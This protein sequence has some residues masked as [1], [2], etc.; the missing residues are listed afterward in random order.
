MNT[1]SMNSLALSSRRLKGMGIL[2]MVF[3]LVMAIDAWFKWQPG[4]INHFTSYLTGSLDSRRPGEPTL[5]CL[6][7]G[8]R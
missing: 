8:G 5:V 3:G 6:S 2:R 1:P 4:F 7:C